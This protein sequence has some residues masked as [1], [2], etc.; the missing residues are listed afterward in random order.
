[1]H[2][3]SQANA[4]GDGS[5]P[6]RIVDILARLHRYGRIRGELRFQTTPVP[7]RTSIS[8]RVERS[9]CR[10][11]ERF[12]IRR[13]DAQR[14]RDLLRGAAIETAVIRC[15]E[16]IGEIGVQLGIAR[17]SATAFEYAATA[18]EGRSSTA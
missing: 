10:Q 3:F 4:H 18:S 15:R 5:Q 17:S 12:R 1:M 16:G 13:I 14:R 7:Y 2:I 6:H 9:R 11:R 8:M